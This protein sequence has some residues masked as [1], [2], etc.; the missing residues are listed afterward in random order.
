MRR[1]YTAN[2]PRAN[3][4]L[5]RSISSR[6]A[7]LLLVAAAQTLAQGQPNPA[8]QSVPVQSKES[9]RRII[10]SIPDHKLALVEHGRIVKVYRVAV[11]APDSPSPEGE[12]RIVRRLSDPTYYHPGVVIPPGPDNPLGP[13]WIG[14]SMK[15]FGIHGTN[16]PTSIGHWASHGCIRMRNED[17]KELFALVRE[18]DAVEL[19]GE[20]DSAIAALFGGRTNEVARADSAASVPSAVGEFS[21]SR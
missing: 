5:K 9:P 10:V 11:G 17:V 2:E 4:I 3:K 19:H 15:G 12:F 20:R 6:V 14:L 21:G 18:G 7:V 13:R 16:Q 8:G 1:S